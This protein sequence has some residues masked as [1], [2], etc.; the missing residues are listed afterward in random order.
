MVYVFCLISMNLKR[1][2]LQYWKSNILFF[3]KSSFC[4]FS[5][6]LVF[7]VSVE[8]KYDTAVYICKMCMWK[9]EKTLTGILLQRPQQ[10]L[11]SISKTGTIWIIIIFSRNVSI[12]LPERPP[13]PFKAALV[14]QSSHQSNILKGE[15]VFFGTDQAKEN[16]PSQLPMD[17]PSRQS[18]GWG[19]MPNELNHRTERGYPQKHLQIPKKLKNITNI[20]KKW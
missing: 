16:D 12:Q 19:D 17:M 10:V 2:L 11:E 20:K 7:V 14:H 5:V 6:N 13:L 8:F 9:K 18:I 4:N 15:N 3:T 1:L